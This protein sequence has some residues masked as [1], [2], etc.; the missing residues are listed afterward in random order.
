MRHAPQHITIFGYGSQGQAQALNL[1]DSGWAVTVAVRAGGTSHAKAEADGFAVLTDNIAAARAAHAAAILTSDRAQPE[2]WQQALN[3]YLPRH[4][5]V[6]FAHGYNIHYRHILPRPDL[7]ILLAAPMCPGAALRARY[8][9]GGTTPI[10]TA[11]HQDASGTARAWLDGFIRAITDGHVDEI[12]SSFAEET[13]T[14]L[15]VEQALLVGGLSHLIV[16]TFDTMVAAGYNPKLAYYWCLHDLR[17]LANLFADY[18]LAE[19]YA[20]VSRTAR[21]GAMTRGPR[22]I[23]DHV[24]ATMQQLLAEVRSGDY[25]RELQTAEDLPAATWRQHL[26]DKLHTSAR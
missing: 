24:R 6:V 20:R 22:V 10:I 4:A 7:H 25:D 11:L 12:R 26:L 5:M 3:E 18:G 19:G 15:F 17:D 8:R 9:D 23:D 13:E 21:H 14:N 2:L 16:A 1:R